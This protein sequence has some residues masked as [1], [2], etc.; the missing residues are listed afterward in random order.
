[1]AVVHVLASSIAADVGRV[2][3]TRIR[4]QKKNIRTKEPQTFRGGGGMSSFSNVSGG[5]ERRDTAEGVT[6]RLR[7]LDGPALAA[8]TA[9]GG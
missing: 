6:R 8:G 4:H 3:N 9:A 7:V 5:V 2:G 1:M